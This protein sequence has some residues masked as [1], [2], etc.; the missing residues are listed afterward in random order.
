MSDFKVQLYSIFSCHYV[1]STE[2]L[3]IVPNV[4]GPLRIFFLFIYFIYSQ[5]DTSGLDKINV[6]SWET[7]LSA[8]HIFV[9]IL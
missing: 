6:S 4:T 7:F 8:I 9:Q 5:S 1:G 2:F 3:Y